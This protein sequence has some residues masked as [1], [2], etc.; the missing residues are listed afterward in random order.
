METT[1]SAQVLQLVS[2]IEKIRSHLSSFL[3][4]SVQFFAYYTL[5]NRIE[6]F[7]YQFYLMAWWSYIIFID[8]VLSLKTGRSTVFNRRFPW[9]VTISCGFLVPLRA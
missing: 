7:M 4:S 1:P 5:L 2:S 6:P 9:L 8:A 3:P